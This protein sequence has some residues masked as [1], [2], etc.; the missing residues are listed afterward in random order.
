MPRS[1]SNDSTGR[2][3]I[4]TA[5]GS[6]YVVNLD[7]RTISRT[8]A[9]TPP[10]V[11]F[12]DAGFS[13]LRRDGEALQLLM[14]ESCEVGSSAVFWIQVRDDHIPTFRRTSPVVCIEPLD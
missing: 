14:L 11:D 9:A 2:F 4:T 5:T 8:M 6:Q 7:D 13:Q 10:L 1:I 3:L 12:L